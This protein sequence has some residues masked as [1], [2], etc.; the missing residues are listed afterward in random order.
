M[1][2]AM[3]VGPDMVPEIMYVLTDEA[4]T[5]LDR[6]NGQ[7]MP[8]LHGHGNIIPGLEVALEGKQVGDHVDVAVAPA[9][10]YGEKTGKTLKVRKREFSGDAPA[11]GQSFAAP[12][13]DGGQVVFWVIKDEGAFLT[14]TPDHPLAGQTLRFSVNVVGLRKATQSE[15][16]HHH[17]HGPGGH[18]HH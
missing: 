12:T 10:A 16:D 7:A 14:I 9:E 4:G 6:S 17:V 15:I 2:E 11:L 13:P 18:H 5:V 3:V 8:Y 1:R